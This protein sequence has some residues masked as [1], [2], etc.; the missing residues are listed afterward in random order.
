MLRGEQ[1][2]QVD[3]S[4]S[5]PSIC[6]ERVES[7]MIDVGLV[8]VAEIARQGLQIVSKVGIAAV[9]AV[10]SILLI[11]R[12]PF[13]QIRRLAV[14]VSSRTSVHLVKI[15]LRERYGV[16]PVLIAQEPKLAEMLEEA[17]A[18]LVI[19][20]SAL[21]IEP[22]T[23]PYACLDLGAEW[24]SLTGLPMVF[25]AWASKSSFRA[26][27]FASLAEDSYSFGREHLTEIVDQQFQLRGIS[28]L[29]TTEYF[30]RHIKFELGRNE[31]LGLD[32]FY[33]LADLVPSRSVSS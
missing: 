27:S 20:D 29:L 16:E 26:H 3:L 14:D 23:L 1:Q 21:R 2:S 15:I 9:G 11:S 22:A 24:L 19:G 18:A 12:V 17:E 10:R 28:R 13:Q 30:A 31:I 6:A 7:G 33:E 25:A 32:A 5:I 4:F 8:P